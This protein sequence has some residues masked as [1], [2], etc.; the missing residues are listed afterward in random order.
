MATSMHPNRHE[1]K[2]TV[3][4]LLI[5]GEIIF[6]EQREAICLDLQRALQRIDWDK[7]QEINDLF[8]NL[9]HENEFQPGLFSIPSVFSSSISS[10]N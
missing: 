6:N 5:I 4:F 8:N 9:I 2:S 7:H 10:L 3:G 1:E